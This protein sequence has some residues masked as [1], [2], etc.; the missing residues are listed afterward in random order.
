M[1]NIEEKKDSL[2]SNVKADKPKKVAGKSS[3]GKKT[4]SGKK[5][6]R[7]NVVVGT[8]HVQAGFNNTLVSI[9][10]L[11]GNVVATSS[12]GALGFKGSRK[13]TPYAAQLT[14]AEAVKKAKECG[15]QSV[16]VKIK[17]SGMGRDSSLK[18]LS[19]SKLGI[20]SIEDITHHPHNGCRAKKKRRV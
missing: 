16:K 12:A 2:N 11:Q 5:R 1:A 18:A 9:S 8:V 20:I 19:D 4:I 14:T 13:S 15:L 3:K 7:R 6:K 17:G 10:D